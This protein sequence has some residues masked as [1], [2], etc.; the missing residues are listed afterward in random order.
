MTVNVSKSSTSTIGDNMTVN[1]NKNRTEAIG[2][3]QATTVAQGYKLQAK[4]IELIADDEIVIKTGS[5]EII[6][7]KNGDISIKGKQ[8]DV[9]GSGDINIK[10][11]GQLNLKGSK[12]N[13]N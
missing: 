2:G 12:V 1:V 8:I 6:L 3:A 10:G 4:R 9:V 11:T 13:Q 7:K 5:A